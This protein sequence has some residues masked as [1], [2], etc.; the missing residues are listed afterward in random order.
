MAITKTT[1]NL[2]PSV[3]YKAFYHWAPND[4][5]AETS[6]YTSDQDVIT[7]KEGEADEKCRVFGREHDAYVSVL[8]CEK[9]EPVCAEDRANLARGPF[10]F[11]SSTI[12]KRLKLRLPLTG[13]EHALLTEVNVAY[14]QLHPNSWAFVRAFSIL[15]N[16]LDHTPSVDV[17]LYF[18]EAKNPGKRLW[19]SFNGVAGRVLLTLF[20]Q[21]YKSFKK[22]F[23]KVS[24]SVH[25]PTLLDG[26]PLYWVEKPGLKKPRSLE[27]LTPPDRE[28]CQ[29][30]SG[31]EAVFDTVKLIKLEFCAKTLKSYI[32]TVLISASH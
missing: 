24:C 26:F 16:H 2:P 19:L 30:F 17:F 31:L 5:L 27:D 14:A 21:S 23:F 12:F 6:K 28:M 25:D 15:C 10:F 32:G 29:L 3:N 4:L 20:Q 22:K 7:Y 18:F 1:P 11:M 9:G 13:F 8:P